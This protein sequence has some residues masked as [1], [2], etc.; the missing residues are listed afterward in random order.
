MRHKRIYFASRQEHERGIVAT[1]CKWGKR[2]PGSWL[3]LDRAFQESCAEHR[4]W[5]WTPGYQLSQ[6]VSDCGGLGLICNLMIYRVKIFFFA[7]QV[8]LAKKWSC[9]WGMH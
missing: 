7:T 6:G 9:A 1:S 8:R 3:N 2:H 5:I 4:C